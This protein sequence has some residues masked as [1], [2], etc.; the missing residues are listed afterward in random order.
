MAEETITYTF[1][2][3]DKLTNTISSLQGKM[4]QLG[5]VAQGVHNIFE[6]I[7]NELT[8]IAPSL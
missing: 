7:L 2:G 3:D 4:I 8:K 1:I 5:V 6:T